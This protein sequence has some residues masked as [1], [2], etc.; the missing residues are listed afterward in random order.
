MRAVT[1]AIAGRFPFFSSGDT[2]DDNTYDDH[3][4]EKVHL[5]MNLIQ[6]YAHESI[7]DKHDYIDYN[8][9]KESVIQTLVLWFK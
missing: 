1:S 5:A 4:E 7:Y 6:S 2:G 9:M 8:A 3:L